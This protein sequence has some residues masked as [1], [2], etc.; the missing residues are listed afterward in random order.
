MTI[1]CALAAGL[2]ATCALPSQAQV[3]TQKDVGVRMGLA[4]AVGNVFTGGAGVGTVVAAAVVVADP[5]PPAFGVRAAGIVGGNAGG[6]ATG[7]AVAVSVVA[8]PGGSGGRR[9]GFGGLT[10]AAG[11][12]DVTGEGGFARLGGKRTS[13]AS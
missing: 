3:I 11:A 9:C 2:V 1:R 10:G 7:V 13:G 4:V 12:P 6:G 5:A 8:S